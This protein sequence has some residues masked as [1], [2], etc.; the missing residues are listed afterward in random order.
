MPAN[1]R[2]DLIRRLK[3]NTG[4]KQEIINYSIAVSSN[5]KVLV[6]AFYEIFM[7]VLFILCVVLFQPTMQIYIYF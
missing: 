4:S 3:V 1:G 7:Y 5:V 6:K 2:W